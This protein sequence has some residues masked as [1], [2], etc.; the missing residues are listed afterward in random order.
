MVVSNKIEG[1]LCAS[2]VEVTDRLRR[3][4]RHVVL[5]QIGEQGQEKLLASSVLM[6]GAGG[7]GSSALAYL[8]AAG[9]GHVG[10][11]E[12]DRVELSNLQRQI[13]FESSDLGR[14]KVE[15]AAD[16][17]SEINE[18]CRVTVFPIR[19]K[20]AN[21]RELVRDFD[22]VVDGSDNFATRFAVAAACMQEKKPL[23]SAAISGFSAQLSTFKPYL[24]KPHP[25]YRCLVPELPE[26][27]ITCAQEGII[28]PLAGVMGSMQA[29]EAVK[30]LLGI[31]DS[32]SGHVLVM[33]ALSMNIRKVALP[34]DSTCAHCGQ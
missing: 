1:T 13:L 5:P 9:V 26:R 19:L 34:R 8:A 32:L 33:D 6:I 24:G 16:R 7:L 17:I 18:D 28:G 27:E 11:V 29:L 21:A 23:I 10:V 15:A 30:E 14:L 20:E 2:P 22:I 3:Y 12:Y 31:G 4:A 25:C